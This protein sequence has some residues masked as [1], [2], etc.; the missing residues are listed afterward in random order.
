MTTLNKAVIWDGVRQ[1]ELPWLAVSG[2]LTSP[3]LLIVQDHDFGERLAETLRGFGRQVLYLE[4]ETM[5]PWEGIGPEPEVVAARYA[6]RNQLRL[7]NRPELIVIS[8]ELAQQKWM[9]DEAFEALC[10]E[11]MVGQE[12][13]PLVFGEKLLGCGFLRVDRV[14]EPGTFTLRGG[15]VECFIP[16]SARPLRFDF[17]GDDLESIQQFQIETLAPTGR[18][19][20]VAI[21]PIR[22]V[23]FAAESVGRLESW[24]RHYGETVAV[25]T[26]RI[27]AYLEDAQAGR[28]FA[29]CDALWPVMM[30]PG[31]SILQTLSCGRAV[32]LHESK[33]LLAHWDERYIRAQSAFKESQELGDLAVEVDEH[34]L[35]VDEIQ[36]SFATV[37]ELVSL[38]YFALEASG[39]SVKL[40]RLFELEDAVALRRKDSALGSLLEPIVAA[41]KEQ[42]SRGGHVL[43]A[44]S[45]NLR[46]E[47]LREL[48]REHRLDLPCVEKVPGAL[49]QGT[50]E[51]ERWSGIVSASIDESFIDTERDILVL[52]DGLFFERRIQK[53]K[54]R[55]AVSKDGLQDLKTL[56]HG[57][58]I[59]HVEHGIG[60]YQGLT[61]LNA[62]GVPGDY[63]Q[64]EYA[65][66]D[67]LYLPVYRLNLLQLYR[68]PQD[69][70]R[71]D[72][73][74][75]VRWEKVR[76]KVKDALIAMAH[77]L[78]EVQARRA[79][80]EG[81]QMERPDEHYYAFEKTFPFKETADQAKAIVEV[82]DDLCSPEP[83]DR[84]ICGDVGFGKTEVALRATFL[85]VSNGFQVLI[86]VPTTV[87]AEQHARRFRE[88]LEPEGINV[89]VLNRFRTKAEQTKIV[90]RLRTGRVDVVI[91]THRLL[92]A[93][94]SPK[95][96]GLLVVDEEHRFGVKHKERIKQ[97]K[98]RV[99]VLAMSATP[100]PRT[101][102]MSLSGIRDVSVISTPPSQRDDIRTEIARFD[103][104][105]IGSAIERELQRG[106]QVFVLHNKVQSIE[107]FAETIRSLVP[108]ARVAVAHGQMTGSKLEAIMV[109]FVR[110]EIQVLVST[111]IIENG[112]DIPSANTMIIDRADTFGLSQLHQIRGRIGRGRQKAYAYL[113]LPRTESVTRDAASRLNIL[114]RFSSL[115]AGYEIARHDLELRGAG[116]LLG[117]EQSGHVAAIGY[118]LYMQLLEDAVEHVKGRKDVLSVEP[119]IKL[120]FSAV[121]PESWMPDPMYRLD[122]YRKLSTALSDDEIWELEEDAVGFSGQPPEEFRSLIEMMLHRRRLKRLGVSVMSVGLVETDLKVALNFVEGA[123]V[124]PAALMSLV[125]SEPKSFEVRPDG[126]LVLKMMTLKNA[127]PH[128]HLRGITK[129]LDRLIQSCVER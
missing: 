38:T 127:E 119:E 68:G 17:F 12:I 66:G 89:E 98:H 64:L 121:I 83:M 20:R 65:D 63:V 49:L 86:L 33:E 122:L 103:E 113:L 94:I 54:K 3:A 106:G 82:I 90:E 52:H 116:D 4:G 125:T 102:Y 110:R 51:R 50:W 109:A 79:A 13:D 95:N 14:E 75:G 81:H 58:P 21:F 93:D 43:V 9:S 69:K 2:R 112:I 1:A 28:Y 70:A 35:D 78:L 37:S 99:N 11:L 74:G 96:L 40:K 45:S 97:L 72:K 117:A 29:G 34:Y 16:G 59:I 124:D 128:S 111:T 80:L 92:S 120:P 25:P 19:E 126:R 85:S 30:G 55:R 107:G 18:L 42:L 31:V 87:L 57:D 56:S 22:D 61:R 6:L 5:T 100:I 88:R 71:L 67:K 105:L 84:L 91:G 39:S 41:V 24:L 8:A 101:L 23:S 104:D 108:G 60:R 114:R 73:L 48:L 32:Y 46:A 26:R 10:F 118:E 44:A 47:R 123:P 36:A 7:G 15:V 53:A 77:Q 27:H 62:G 129:V 115:G 76:K